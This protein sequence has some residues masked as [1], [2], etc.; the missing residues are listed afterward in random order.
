MTSI[1]CEAETAFCDVT[2]FRSYESCNLAGESPFYPSNSTAAEST[3]L[4]Q[5]ASG[6]GSCRS[7]GEHEV[8]LQI[9]TTGSRIQLFTA[10]LENDGES[11]LPSIKHRKEISGFASNLKAL[12]PM[13]QI[14]F[15]N[16]TIPGSS[17]RFAM[18]PFSHQNSNRNS[19]TLPS[20]FTASLSQHYTPGRSCTPEL[21]GHND[22]VLIHAENS[23]QS[24][25]VLLKPAKQGHGGE[26]TPHLPNNTTFEHDLDLLSSRKL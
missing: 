2:T 25:M 8:N 24:D 22:S 16:T 26:I 17:T 4:S 1:K 7:F 21:L 13:S 18:D 23:V 12:N 20:A 9:S 5:I 11:T 6:A 10:L 14:A 3:E 15:S 19:G